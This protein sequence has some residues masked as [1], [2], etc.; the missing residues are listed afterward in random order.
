MKIR[1][2]RTGDVIE[3]TQTIFDSVRGSIPVG[4]KAT[5]I[6]VVHVP[7]ELFG[8][9]QS[10]RESMGHTQHLKVR[11]SRRRQESNVSGAYFK[12]V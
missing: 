2:F 10:R 4:T 6:K 5:V 3:T 12:K 7:D 8:F 9:T 1:E 11:F